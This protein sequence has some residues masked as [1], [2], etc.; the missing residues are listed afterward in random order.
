MN[1]TQ[2]I[3]EHMTVIDDDGQH[4]GTVDHVE[5]NNIKLT[6]NDSPD[7]E[8]HLISADLIDSIEGDQIRLN[9][10]AEQIFGNQN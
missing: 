3:R 9:R 4:V 7:G 8:H 10:K 5:G 6:R 1:K 2:D